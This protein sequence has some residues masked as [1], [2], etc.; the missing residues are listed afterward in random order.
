MAIISASVALYSSYYHGEVTPDRERSDAS[1]LEAIEKLSSQINIEIRGDCLIIHNLMDKIH[2]ANL[3][4][5]SRFRSI[6][7]S[8]GQ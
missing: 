3:S 4:S 5:I 7:E 6:S 2:N 1:T 8:S